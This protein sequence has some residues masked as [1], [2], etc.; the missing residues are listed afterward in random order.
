VQSKDPAAVS[1]MPQYY[2]H[3]KTI[4]IKELHMLKYLYYLYPVTILMHTTYGGLRN[5]IARYHQAD[6]IKDREVD[7]A[8]GTGGREEKSVQGFGSQRRRW[9]NGIGMDLRETGCGAGGSGF[10]WL[11]IGTVGGLP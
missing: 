9:E 11:R 1:N 8:C 7:I 4:K 10:I 2:R 3:L 6:Q 5:F